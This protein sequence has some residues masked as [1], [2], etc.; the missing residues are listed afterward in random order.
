MEHVEARVKISQNRLKL[1]V[2]FTTEVSKAMVLPVSI[3]HKSVAGHYRP[4][5]VAEGP[6]KAR[7]RFIKNISWAGVAYSLYD[8]V[9][10]RC[11][12]FFIF[13]LVRCLI[14]VFDGSC[15]ALLSFRWGRREFVFLLLHVY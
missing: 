5:R 6:I 2:V 1:P 14:V 11:G 9:L 7:Y 15:L 4:V 3:L 8:L 12:T 13:C 10:V